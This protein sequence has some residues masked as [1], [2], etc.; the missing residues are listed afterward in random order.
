MRFA[1]GD[2][3]MDIP[4]VVDGGK[5]DDDGHGLNRCMKA[6]DFVVEL[7]D[8]YLFIEFKDPQHPHATPESRDEFIRRL[9]AGQLD[10]D[11]KYKYRDSFLY[12]MGIW[13]RRQAYRLPGSDCSG[14]VGRDAVVDPDGGS[15]AESAAAWTR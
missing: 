2:L 8:R 11:L 3:E 15:G 1:E 9:D 6:V 12:V 13:A 10:E 4:D 5:F 14:H 7:A